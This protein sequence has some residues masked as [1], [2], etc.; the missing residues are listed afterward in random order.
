MREQGPKEILKFFELTV[1][2]CHL[3]VN[4]D[5]AGIDISLFVSH[6]ADE[7]LVLVS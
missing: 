6:V 2:P 7:M 1:L 4:P 3:I 5:V